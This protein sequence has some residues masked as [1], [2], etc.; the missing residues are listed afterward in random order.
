VIW[1]GA[2]PHVLFV[3]AE[4]VYPRTPNARPMTLQKVVNDRHEYN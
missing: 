2:K 4:R 3:R 1:A